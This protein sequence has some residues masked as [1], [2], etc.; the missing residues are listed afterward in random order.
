MTCTK[1]IEINGDLSFP[2]GKCIA[3]RIQRTQ[4]WAV[5]LVHESVFWD[6]SIFVTLTYSDEHLPEDNKVSKRELQMFI[7]RLRYNLNDR[8]IK[9]YGCGEY[10]DKTNRCHYHLIVFGMEPKEKYMLEAAWNK[11]IVHVGTVTLNSCRYVASY[12]QKKIYGDITSRNSDVFAIQSQGLGLSWALSSEEYL[13]E[14]ERM[15]QNGIVMSIPRYYV[16]KLGLDLSRSQTER[17]EEKEE[18]LQKMMDQRGINN[19]QLFDASLLAKVQKDKNLKAGSL[20]KER[21]KL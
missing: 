6:S 7:K 16:K 14:Y 20:V 2:C 4:E 10:G 12:I 19:E 17:Q 21:K 18:Q 15:T 9:Y 8:K 11:G 5:R 3:C 1:P 13:R